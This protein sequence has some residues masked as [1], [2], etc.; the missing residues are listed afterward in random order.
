MQWQVAEDI[1]PW[2][3]R[4]ADYRAAVICWI[5]ACANS[6]RPPAFTKI[7]KIFDFVKTGQDDDEAEKIFMQIVKGKGR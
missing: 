3:E 1:E 2:G 7:M 6:K 5:I 4:R